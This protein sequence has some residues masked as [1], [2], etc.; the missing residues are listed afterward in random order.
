M[1]QRNPP[2]IATWLLEHIG[3]KNPS[4]AGDLIE[5]YRHGRSIAWY[6]RQVLIA[7]IVTPSKAA[8]LLVG[9]VALYRLGTH[10]PVPG[11]NAQVLALLARRANGTTLPIYDVI[12]GGN[13]S[14][15]T[16]FALGITPF[17]SASILVQIVA[18]GW[19]SLTRRRATP[20]ELPIVRWTWAIA[21][22]LALFQAGSMAVFLERQNGVAGGL[23]FL[24]AAGWGFRLSTMLTLT[25]G[26][27]C[28]MWIGDR[29]TEHHI[30]NGMFLVFVAALL[31][32][33]PELV[34]SSG[35]SVALRHL[36]IPLAVVGLTSHGYQR[37]IQAQRAS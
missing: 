36:V 11:A 7:I 27:A 35:V 12:S 3:R 1:T 17:I 5:E 31:T 34:D 30:S 26:S 21:I 24:D 9:L 14:A 2:E 15:V 4:L 29:I 32:G 13:L 19:W 33:L 28:L 8:L 37:A 18:C 6:W 10:V 20:W 25:A 16:V 23:Q 22:V